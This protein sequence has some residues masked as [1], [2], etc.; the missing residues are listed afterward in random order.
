MK[1]RKLKLSN[2][3]KCHPKANYISL[4]ENNRYV[5]GLFLRRVEDK[6]FDSYEFN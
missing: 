2:F 4:F 1:A 6:G 5:K 3:L